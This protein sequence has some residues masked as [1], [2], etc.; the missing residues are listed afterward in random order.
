[1]SFCE[2]RVSVRAWGLSQHDLKLQFVCPL[3]S[4][5]CK[6]PP[7]TLATCFWWS[8]LCRPLN[9]GHGFST[10][11][12]CFISVLCEDEKNENYSLFI[13]FNVLI[14]CSV[15]KGGSQ[16]VNL[17]CQT[18]F[19]RHSSFKINHVLSCAAQKKKKNPDKSKTSLHINL[20]FLQTL[21]S[22][23]IFPLLMTVVK[24]PFVLFP[25]IKSA[26]RIKVMGE[27]I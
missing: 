18:Q 26:K 20:A 25:K 17:W 14:K 4:S 8:G 12:L 27:K 13:M 16:Y 22:R 10:G 9:W 5:D 2:C 6:P 21:E 3:S 24:A 7:D 19:P 1:M 23:Y 15:S 11:A